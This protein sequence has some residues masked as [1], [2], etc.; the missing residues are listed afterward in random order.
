MDAFKT[1]PNEL[2][3]PRNPLY[4]GDNQNFN[5]YKDTLENFSV[6]SL[7]QLNELLFISGNNAFEPLIKIIN[8]FF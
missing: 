7:I 4:T 5:G 1:H 6:R 2:A 3:K 8:D